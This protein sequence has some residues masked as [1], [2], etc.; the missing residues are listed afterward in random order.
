M[1]LSTRQKTAGI[2][3]AQNG[4]GITT[5]ARMYARQ[6]W[7]SQGN[8]VWARARNFKVNDMLAMDFAAAEL[9]HLFKLRDGSIAEVRKSKDF[10]YIAKRMGG[11]HVIIKLQPNYQEAHPNISKERI[12]KWK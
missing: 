11:S 2:E 1:K 6:F 10:F 4:V 3:Q 12:E 9:R 5:T 8:E 7:A